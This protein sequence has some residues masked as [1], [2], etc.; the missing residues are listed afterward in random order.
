[1]STSAANMEAAELVP[2]DKNVAQL[3]LQNH[4][5]KLVARTGDCPTILVM[6]MPER[7][8]LS[9][10]N[11]DV[12]SGIAFATI[13]SAGAAFLILADAE[14]GAIMALEPVGTDLASAYFGSNSG[15][16]ENTYYSLDLGFSPAGI[17]EGTRLELGVLMVP[18][19]YIGADGSIDPAVLSDGTIFSMEMTVDN[20]APVVN[21]MTLTAETLTVNITDNE[22]V[23]AVA[24][25]DSFGEYVYTVIGSDATATAGATGDFVL[26]LTDVNGTGFLVAVYD[27]AGNLS[28]YELDETIGTTTDVVESVEVYPSTM[29]LQKGESGFVT[30]AVYPV[31]ATN[32]NYTWSSSD[33]SVV[34][35]DEYGN[36]TAVAEGNAKIIATSVTD[37]TITG[38][39]EVTVLDIH[40]NLNAIVWDENGSIYFSEFSTDTMPEYNK[41]SPDMLGMDYFASVAVAPDGTMYV[42]SL[43]GSN[44]TSNLYTVNPA[45]WEF[46]P[47]AASP[48]A[49]TDMTYAPEIF[50]TGA[51][52]GTYGPYVLAYDPTTGAM[53]NILDDF[54]E[55]ILVGVASVYSGYNEDY[56]LYEDHLVIIDSEGN[57]YYEIYLSMI[58]P[59][60]GAALSMCATSDDDGNHEPYIVTGV[61]K[62]GAMYYN[63]A[64]YEADS[65]LVFWSAFD[66]EADNNVTLYAIDLEQK[67]VVSMG[68][69]ADDVWPVGGLFEMPCLHAHTELRDEAAGNC[70]TPGYS[71]DLYCTDCD[72]LLEEGHDTELDPDNH[73]YEDEVT[74]P[75]TASQGYTTHTCERCGHSY[76]DTYTDKLPV[77]GSNSDTGENVH[78]QLWVPML[79][80]SAAAVT[81]LTVYRKKLI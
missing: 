31:N 17:P 62:S 26:D 58:N 63:S 76:V 7:N 70:T 61:N 2:I 29:V 75:T 73:S 57:L 50:G 51:I 72:K 3:V 1:M 24:L 69:F 40:A 44:L 71:G 79:M 23:A 68:Q 43:D 21:D 47:L 45:T 46:T 28:V 14:S 81:V 60:T 38:V 52:L 32:R 41:I 74:P 49:L 15:V 59:N 78:L 56:G 80:V 25:L 65:G 33:E 10:T 36:V 13:R 53:M 5:Q 39:C 6:V 64:Y 18:E 16:W 11:G 37:P 19:Y 12:M 30:A 42:A 48:Y 22:Y 67:L 20:T 9:A 54:G 55:S 34:T 66:Q 4:F 35:V 77:D 27:Y 8:A